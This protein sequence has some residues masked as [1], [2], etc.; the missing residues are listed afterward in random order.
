MMRNRHY[1]LLYLFFYLKEIVFFIFF[2]LIN[3]NVDEVLENISLG[4]FKL[5]KLSLILNNTIKYFL[6]IYSILVLI[7]MSQQ[8]TF[9][10]IRNNWKKNNIEISSS[11]LENSFPQYKKY[12]CFVSKIDRMIIYFNGTI[13]LVIILKLIHNIYLLHQILSGVKVSNLNSKSIIYTRWKKFISFMALFFI[14]NVFSQ[15]VLYDFNHSEALGLDPGYIVTGKYPKN[16]IL[17]T[18]FD[19]IG[20]F[21]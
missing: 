19:I 1:H 2:I 16:I 3:E 18:N 14:Y 9:S 10:F 7:S 11:Y 20:F 4:N 8:F 12:D 17:L 13:S 5:N 15:F 21:F 6:F